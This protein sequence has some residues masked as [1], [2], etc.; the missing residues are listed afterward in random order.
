MLAAHDIRINKKN[1]N[2]EHRKVNKIK[3][4]KCCLM[5][6]KKS[7]SLQG[8]GR[9]HRGGDSWIFSVFGV[10]STCK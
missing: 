10:C 4:R 6:Y 2:R 9:L 1:P 7:E 3:N 8:G 5:S